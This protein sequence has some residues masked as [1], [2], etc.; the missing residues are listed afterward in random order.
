M[1]HT[2]IEKGT[3]VRVNRTGDEGVVLEVMPKF[4]M[5]RVEFEDYTTTMPA[6]FFVGTCIS[7]MRHGKVL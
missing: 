7:G 2:K 4:G 6:A 3:R 1:S 5:V